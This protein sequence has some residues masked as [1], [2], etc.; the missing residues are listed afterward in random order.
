MSLCGAELRVSSWGV[1]VSITLSSAFAQNQPATPDKAVYAERGLWI[2]AAAAICWT[3][4]GLESIVRP[5]QAN[6]RDALVMAP[7][8]LTTLAFWFMHQV[9]R[10]PGTPLERASFYSVMAGSALALAGIVGVQLN[11]PALAVLGFPWGAVLWAG[12]LILFGVAAARARVFPSYVG[13]A[14]VLLEPGSILTG[15][16][17]SPIAPLREHG[18]YTA[19]VEKG[20]VLALVSLGFLAV[21]KK[22]N[23]C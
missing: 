8:V 18:A 7:F 4:L 11:Q 21:R 3:A 9:Q 22:G 23:S 1:Y 20:A 19:G 2:A 17:L 12:G 6:Y 13:I 16:A 15:L 14:I 10:S 5:V